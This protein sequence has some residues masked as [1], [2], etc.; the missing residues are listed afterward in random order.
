M[1]RYFSGPID[2]PVRPPA[3]V[4]MIEFDIV[5]VEAE[6]VRIDHGVYI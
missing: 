5:G 6:L 2:S 4:E 3:P 1:L